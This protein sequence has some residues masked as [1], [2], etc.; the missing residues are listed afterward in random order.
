MFAWVVTWSVAAF[1]PFPGLPLVGLGSSSMQWSIGP[2]IA[3]QNAGDQR[4][5]DC[6]SQENCKVMIFVILSAAK[7]LWSSWQIP[8]QQ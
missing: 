3:W 7:N 5:F 8:A 6:N 1:G 4:E 2:C